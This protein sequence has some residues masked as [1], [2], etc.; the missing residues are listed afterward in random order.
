MLTLIVFLLILTVS[1]VIHELAHY[2]NARS[3]GVPVNAL[4]L[5]VAV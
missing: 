3:V 5:W 1:V 4:S 2:F